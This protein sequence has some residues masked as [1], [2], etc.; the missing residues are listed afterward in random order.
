MQNVLHFPDATAPLDR[1][2]ELARAISVRT[3]RTQA[4][5]GSL[6]SSHPRPQHGRPMRRQGLLQRNISAHLG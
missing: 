3:A 5:L 6:R 2:L 1:M 4:G